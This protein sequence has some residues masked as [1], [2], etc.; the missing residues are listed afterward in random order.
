MTALDAEVAE[1]ERGE[2]QPQEVSPRERVA[3]GSRTA[4][5]RPVHRRC[6]R[7]SVVSGQQPGRVDDPGQNAPGDVFWPGCMVGVGLVGTLDQVVLHQLLGWHHFYDRSTSAV[8]LA[9]D[10]IFHAVSTLLLLLGG[11]LLY[12]DR[13]R[14]TEN[15]ARRAWAALLLGGGAFNFYD[16]TIQHKLLTLHQVRPGVP[17][18]TPYDVVFIGLSVLVLAAGW[19]LLRRTPSRS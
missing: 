12:R 14:L 15:E 16:G 1:T 3:R 18:Q 9:S 5:R 17:D 19:A 10:G 2:E 4:A 11:Y 7:R 13:R 6:A 8:G